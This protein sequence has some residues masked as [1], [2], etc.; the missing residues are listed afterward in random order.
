MNYKVTFYKDVISLL[1]QRKSNF[2]NKLKHLTSSIITKLTNKCQGYGTSAQKIY[3]LCKEM[4]Q[5]TIPQKRIIVTTPQIANEKIDFLPNT[6]KQ[7]PIYFIF[8]NKNI[9]SSQTKFDV[10]GEVSNKTIGKKVKRKLTEYIAITIQFVISNDEQEYTS[11]STKGQLLHKIKNTLVHQ[12]AH[13][14]DQFSKQEANSYSSTSSQQDV[15]YLKYLLK[16]TQI[17]SHFNQVFNTLNYRK[18]SYDINRSAKNTYKN[19][20]QMQEYGLQF[21]QQ[22]KSNQRK[23]Y[24]SMKQI[25]ATRTIDY[26]S[27]SALLH[28]ISEL[29]A[30]DRQQNIKKFVVDYHIAFARDYNEVMKTRYYDK[31]FPNSKVKSLQSMQQFLFSVIQIYKRLEKTWR[32]I[33]YQYRWDTQVSQQQKEDIRKF[34]NFKKGFFDRKQ[35]QQIFNT[36]S[37]M[38]LDRVS[39]KI[40]EQFEEEM[41]I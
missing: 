27:K 4:S 9:N 10:E 23:Y 33:N 35:F 39:E 6:G 29:L 17:R 38:Q 3:A 19:A 11:N 36:Y 5:N 15:K 20:V 7:I 30:A 26:K 40:I 32:Q 16:P 14:F 25:D 34:Y 12:I 1:T 2:V 28:V 31:L 37:W 8:K 24:K 13:Y 18:S 22:K 21:N 41:N